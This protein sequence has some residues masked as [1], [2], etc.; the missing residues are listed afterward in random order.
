MS[1]RHVA[2]GLVVVLAACGASGSPG[3][4][5]LQL[6]VDTAL[7]ASVIERE[8]SR[9]LEIALAGVAGATR[10]HSLSEAG[11]AVV[12]IELDGRDAFAV[13]REVMTR[14]GDTPLPAG[15]MPQLGPPTSPDG[16]LL[17]YV[18]RGRAANLVELR[19]IQ[20]WRVRRRLLAIAGVADVA[21]CGGRVEE[22]HVAVD[23]ARLAT[24]SLADLTEALRRPVSTA[25]GAPPGGTLTVR[26]A[27]ATFG[28]LPDL[29]VRPGDV[30]L[31]IKDLATVSRDHAPQDCFAATHGEEVVAGTVWL[32]AGADRGTVRETA[33]QAL[34]AIGRELPPGVSL[35]VIAD[36]AT[37]IVALPER[38]RDDQL[39]AWRTVTE[40]ALVEL[41][42]AEGGFVAEVP[43]ELRVY[44]AD[45]ATAAAAAAAIATQTA[46]HAI[47]PDDPT[48]W[49]RISGPELA[50]LARL[51]DQLAAGQDVL[52]RVGLATRPE[53]EV[54]PD[55]ARLAELGVG[56]GALEETVGAALAGLSTVD[57]QDGDRRIP[58]L[59]VL[60]PHLQDP[61]ALATIRLGRAERG[62]VSVGMVAS[63]ATRDGPR[64]ILRDG[65]TRWVGLRVRAPDLASLRERVAALA[66]PQG[67]VAVV[68]AAP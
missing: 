39:R 47:A 51:A 60:G 13:R 4:R 46:G 59:V 34:D 18:L 40:S 44:A 11:H 48:A 56:V 54:T 43:D 3:R 49:I 8:I 6:S 26:G 42:R 17:R 62:I 61:A 57:V 12:T 41:G 45:R 9:P 31:R 64:A 2:I 52:E 38:A 22:I 15:V 35:E 30:P 7:S 58:L 53:I 16:T 63:I 68:T 19:T 36:D 37:A 20:D 65:G 28:D 66:L 29:V 1:L 24:V 32:L 25:T 14:L 50:Q 33:T 5:A 67:Y 55:R 10:V 27:L 23:P 21:T